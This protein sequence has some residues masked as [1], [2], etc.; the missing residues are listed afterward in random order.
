MAIRVRCKCGKSLKISSKLADKRIACPAC[1]RPFRIPAAKFAAAQQK[2]AEK[3]KPTGKSSQG[4]AAPPTKPEAPADPLPANLDDELAAAGS[5]LIDFSQS[6]VLNLIDEPP[7]PPAT[8]VATAPL[9]I[10]DAPQQVSYAADPTGRIAGPRRLSDPISEPKRSFWKDAFVS[11]IYPAHTANNAITLAVIFF[12][13]AIEAFLASI[14]MPMCI[15]G[16]PILIIKCWFA[17][18]YFSVIRETAAGSEDLPGLSLEG[19]WFEA[20]LVP[21]LKYV[22]AF[23]VVFFPF[24]VMS[25]LSATGVL[26]PSL[27]YL[28]PILF[29]AGVFMVPMSCLLFALEVPGALLKLHVVLTTIAK[30]ILPYLAMWLMLALILVALMS[31][32]VGGNLMLG[33]LFPKGWLTTSVRTFAAT[34]AGR[35]VVALLGVY[36]MIVAMRVIGL[37]Y[38]HFKRRFAFVME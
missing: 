18:L 14:P 13:G 1:A 34:I 6:D 17:S 31:V 28:L 5:G 15:V 12:F 19:G 29:M 21:A 3:A 20:I 38:L 37:Y 33:M 30:T 7:P 27:H 24:V 36:L 8:E 9:T 22:G 26:P 2:A 35:V 32:S 16:V 23:A 25:I 11:F 4:D 10:A